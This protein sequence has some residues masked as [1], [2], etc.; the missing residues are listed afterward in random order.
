MKGISTWEIFKGCFKN[1]FFGVIGEVFNVGGECDN[2]QRKTEALGQQTCPSVTLYIIHPAWNDLEVN[3][4]FYSH[5]SNDLG[6]SK[7]VRFLTMI[8]TRR[9][10]EPFLENFQI[11]TKRQWNFFLHEQKKI[12]HCSLIILMTLSLLVFIWIA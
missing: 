9:M 12:L 8:E 11:M 10:S 3:P 5:N 4:V 2:Q 1:F 6:Y 7:Q